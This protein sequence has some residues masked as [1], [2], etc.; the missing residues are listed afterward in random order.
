MIVIVYGL[1]GSGKTYF[2]SH[3]AK[4]LEAVYI[5]TDR[6]RNQRMS[7]KS[8][9]EEEKDAVY[10]AV[11]DK[12]KGLVQR[13]NDVVV[14]G[15]FYKREFLE[16]FG[17]EPELLDSIRFIEVQAEE[18]VIRQ[19][20]ARPRIDSEADWSVYKKI[21]KQWLPKSVRRLVL[22]STDE[23]LEEMLGEALK[24]LAADDTGR[25]K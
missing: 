13:G 20:L 19:R 1:P 7:S 4:R 25:N 22:Q 24:Y 9:S 3:L 23:N 12:T 2:A 5:S 18:N 16:Q 6:M 15:T 21:K 11:L 17:R 8:Y 14:D 10:A